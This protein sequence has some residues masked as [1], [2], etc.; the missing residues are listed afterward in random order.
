MTR[1]A[2]LQVRTGSLVAAAILGV[3]AV[4]AAVT[5]IQLAHLYSTDVVHC[6]I[7]CGL[8]LQEFSNHDG[9]LQQAFDV[10]A[11]AVPALLGLFWGAPLLARELETGSYRLAWTQS[12]SRSRWVLTKLA[13]GALGTVTAA[14][15]LTL[16][17][18][19]WYRAL[20]KAGSN[21]Y[22]LFDRRDVAPIG[23]ALF[24]FAA[25]ALIGVLVRRVVASM[26]ATLAV[27]VAARIV[28]AVWLR[29]HLLPP[30]HKTMSLLSADGF[31][32]ESNNGAPLT[33][34]AKGAAGSNAWTVSSQI[35][36]SSGHRASS[37]QLSA[38][39]HQYCPG[40]AVPPAPVP[41]VDHPIPAP[42][43]VAASFDACR[44]EAARFFHLFVTYQPA[45]RYWPLQWLETGVFV[46]LALA[47]LGGCYWWVTR[48]AG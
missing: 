21:H 19:W 23:Y 24:A 26:A 9:F 1:F 8:A 40:I 45:G 6:Q 2:W 39:L 5:G 4:V 34:A 29:S 31:G 46:V 44:V 37:A 16:V 15:I 36:T 22:V 28:T 35:L 30:L 3:L 13:V 27:F 47:A 32:F 14:G 20:D 18:T 33:I 25:G 11:R 41:G 12:V 48:R 38:F 42:P 17:I 43:K 7:G 10:L